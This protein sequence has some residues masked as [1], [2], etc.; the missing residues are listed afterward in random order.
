M[1][2][3]RNTIMKLKTISVGFGAMLMLAALAVH[4]EDQ[5]THGACAL[6]KAGDLKTLMGAV[7]SYSSKRGACTWSVAGSPTK[8]ITTKFPDTGM[9]AEMAY[10]NIE[11][12][13]AKG[14]EIISVKGLGD[15]AFARFN[16]AG[17]VLITIKNG[18][19]LQMIYATGSL[20]TQKE[21]DALKPI[22]KKA[23][24]GF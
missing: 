1:N 6:V 5:P 23:I 18:T 17:V 10:S 16:R 4:A 3:E 15:K 22:A 11:K 8:L 14:G 21:L 13:A 12:N 24:A 19:L 2:I 20:G 7:P 9:A